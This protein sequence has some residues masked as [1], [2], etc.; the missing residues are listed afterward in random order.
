[1]LINE[2]LREHM[3][4][5][6][7]STKR[8]MEILTSNKEN[9]SNSLMLA[10]YEDMDAR[11]SHL[12]IDNPNSKILKNARGQIRA[13]KTLFMEHLNIIETIKE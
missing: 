8:V 7:N 12:I 10:Y 2:H 3:E 6:N 1:M 4:I 5:S 9:L 11:L 13:S